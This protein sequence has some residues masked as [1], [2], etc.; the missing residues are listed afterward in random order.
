MLMGG[1]LM[2]FELRVT[3]GSVAAFPL[4]DT[5]SDKIHFFQGN[6]QPVHLRL[7]PTCWRRAEQYLDL[8]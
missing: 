6:L 7:M 2:V 1:E 4:D 5:G 3:P 8:R